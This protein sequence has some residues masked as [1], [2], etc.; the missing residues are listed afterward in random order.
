MQLISAFVGLSLLL[1]ADPVLT[2]APAEPQALP[3]PTAAEA[4]AEAAPTVAATTAPATGF[5]T[6]PAGALVEIELVNALSSATSK[7]GDRFPIRL[8]EPIV[9]DGVVVVPAGALGEGEVI[10]VTGAGIN[11]K[12]GKLIISA[13]F[14]ELNGQR[15]RI[16]GMS[17][18]ATGKSR[19]DLATGM[20]LVPYVGLAT[21][22]VRGGNIE[23]PAGTRATAKLAQAVEL[24]ISV[25]DVVGGEVK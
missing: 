24:P 2:P 5:V 12:Q 4:P 8:A 10:D 20:M 11:G 9:V 17:I 23:M 18:I 1:A 15:V 19:V 22:F 14:L 3:A 13:R 21:V 6:L 16:R 7:L 25:T